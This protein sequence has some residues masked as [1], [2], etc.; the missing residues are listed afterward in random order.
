MYPIALHIKYET[1]NLI[2]FAF[3]PEADNSDGLIREM[4]WDK[5]KKPGRRY[6]RRIP[7]IPDPFK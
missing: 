7:P 6:N 4:L 2:G 3:E 5:R 1:R